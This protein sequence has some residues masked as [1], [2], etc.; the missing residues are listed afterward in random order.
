M[1]CY[2]CGSQIEDDSVFCP[3]CGAKLDE[4]TNPTKE[5]EE[6]VE[7]IQLQPKA[8]KEK[9]PISKAIIAAI[10]AVLVVVIG[11]VAFVFLYKPTIHLDD[12]VTITYEGYNGYGTALVEVDWEQFKED[13]R[14]KLKWTSYAKKEVESLG[15]DGDT[16]LSSDPIDFF[17]MVISASL[18]KSSE[19]S[20]DDVVKVTWDVADGIEKEVNA[21]IIYD[22]DKEYTVSGLEEISEID[23]FENVKVKYDGMDGEG[24]VSGYECKDEDMEYYL[25]A[26]PST[27]L[28]VGDKITVSVSQD[29]LDTYIEKYG[30]S[31][32]ETSKE[33]TVEEL[34]HYAEK[35]D[36]LPADI[37]TSAQE[38]VKEVAED[39]IS[40][41]KVKAET[42]DVTYEYVGSYLQARKDM[43]NYKSYNHI[44]VYGL[45][46]KIT[47]K[48]NGETTVAYNSI[49][50]LNIKVNGDDCDIDLSNYTTFENVTV[51]VGSLDYSLY[52]FDSLESLESTAIDKYADSYNTDFDYK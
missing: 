27:N 31:P 50:Y 40:R 36:E 38:K 16:Y 22:N 46:Y 28:S 48:R 29:Y 32:K 10:V 41:I 30:K 1:Y 35:L 20:N 43:E 19:L 51:Q 34:Q 47:V 24:Y 3:V 6:V 33:F 14:G 12:Y 7:P 39:R 17:D 13:Y 44:N 9:K 21:T 25:S 18:D 37:Q 26:E 11:V 15:F 42:D 2:K 49:E 52:G 5:M 45:V 4:Q 23:I 8:P